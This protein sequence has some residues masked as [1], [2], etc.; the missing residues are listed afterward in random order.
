MHQLLE[1]GGITQ[2]QYDDMQGTIIGEVKICSRVTFTWIIIL[3]HV[4]NIAKAV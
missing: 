2:Q 1:R 3:T 4:E